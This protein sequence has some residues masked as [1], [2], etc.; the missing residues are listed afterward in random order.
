MRATLVRYE[1]RSRA[2]LMS[3][4]P[5][6]RSLDP[7]IS[8]VDS[9][10][11]AR[12]PRALARCGRTLRCARKRRPR[13]ALEWTAASLPPPPR[14]TLSG[15]AAPDRYQAATLIIICAERRLPRCGGA[16]VAVGAIATAAAPPPPQASRVF[17]VSCVRPLFVARMRASLR[18]LIRFASTWT[19]SWLASNSN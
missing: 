7:S 3:G 10:P 19:Q 14:D 2:E 16:P 1:R 17:V 15:G 8:F 5:L 4:R 18:R 13:S 6:A 12:A 9:Q 11:V